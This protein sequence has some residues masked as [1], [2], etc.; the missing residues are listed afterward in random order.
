VHGW[1]AAL[2]QACAATEGNPPATRACRALARSLREV[3]AD[4]ALARQ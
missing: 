1:G 2:E 4:T 3:A